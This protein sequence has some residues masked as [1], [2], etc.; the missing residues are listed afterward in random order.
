MVIFL[1]SLELCFTY[2]LLLAPPR[3]YLE[4]AVLSQSD[5]KYA[6]AIGTLLRLSLVGLTIALALGVSQ[7]GII[8]GFV[9][10]LTDSLQVWLWFLDNQNP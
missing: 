5:A 1:L 7:F 3:Q 9:G 6:P 8:T 4:Q 10:G 2:V